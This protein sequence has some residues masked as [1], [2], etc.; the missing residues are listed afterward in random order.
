MTH[1]GLLVLVPVASLVA[2]FGSVSPVATG[3]SGRV[4]T[5]AAIARETEALVAEAVRQAGAP[6]SV[7]RLLSAMAPLGTCVEPAVGGGVWALVLTAPPAIEAQQLVDPG[8]AFDEAGHE[9]D[10][11]GTPVAWTV[12]RAWVPT[13]VTAEGARLA[14]ADPPPMPAFDV[15]LDESG[16]AVGPP[17]PHDD[18]R[19]TVSVAREASAEGTF[20][21]AFQGLYAML[22]VRFDGR[23]LVLDPAQTLLPN[24]SGFRDFNKDGRDDL[25]DR[26]TLTFRMYSD[27]HHV[28]P[29]DLVALAL[30]DG[31]WT[32]RHP[33]V[34]AHY[35]A[36]CDGRGRPPWVL[37]QPSDAD[38]ITNLACARLFGVPVETLKEGLARE[39]ATLSEG[40]DATT[41]PALSLFRD[42]F[43]DLMAWLDLKLP[44]I[45]TR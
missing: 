43:D 33:E 4:A 15:Y 19:V 42:V 34:E 41:V 6:V 39:K 16:A 32:T 25:F 35:R 23:S 22:L 20:R 10:A 13:F 45:A 27:G 44:A 38:A 28:Q 14:L 17:G 21:A 24:L 8:E 40:D 26:E 11:A 9:T 29:F 12:V 7:D 3:P 5:C 1:R 37:G 36:A 30:P 2:C 31:T 18:Q